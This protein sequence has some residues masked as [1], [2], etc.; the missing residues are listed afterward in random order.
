LEWSLFDSVSAIFEQPIHD[1]FG[2]YVMDCQ[3]P[4]SLGTA[5]PKQILKAIYG[6]GEESAWDY[7]LIFLDNEGK[8][9]KLKITDLTFQYY[10][11]SL[12]GP[13]RAPARIAAELTE[14]LKSCQV[15]LRIGLARSWKMFPERCY[16][17]ITGVYTFPDYLDGKIFA[18]FAPSR[19]RR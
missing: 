13:D 9:Y 15:Y 5:C 6:P 3:G 2:F 19:S 10:C 12:R 18:D 1:D 4:R 14:K 17:Q 7:R 8:K 16:L 11:N